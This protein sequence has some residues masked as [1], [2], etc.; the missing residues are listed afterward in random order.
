ML[1]GNHIFQYN[2]SRI[3]LNET[4][5]DNG[6]VRQETLKASECVY[7]VNCSIWLLMIF[8]PFSRIID[9]TW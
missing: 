8:V 7:P 5:L 4:I 6:N 2:L 9:V 1:S 3:G